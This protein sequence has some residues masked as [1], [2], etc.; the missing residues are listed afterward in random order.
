MAAVYSVVGYFLDRNNYKKGHVAYRKLD[1]LAA[2]NY[3]DSVINQWR[4]S[5]FGGYASLAYQEK[6]EC[7]DFQKALAQQE[8][9]NLPQALAAYKTFISKHNT[10]INNHDRDSVLV[11]A[12]RERIKSL[13]ESSEATALENPEVC[14][15]L[16]QLIQE[17]QE[18]LIPESNTK[19]SPLYVFCGENY[20]ANR[21]YNRAITMY[22]GFIAQYPHHA[23]V[24][25][26]EAALAKLLVAQAQEEGAGNLPALQREGNTGDSSS[27]VT[28][29]NNSPEPMRIVFSGPEGRIEKLEECGS[30]RIYFGKPPE[31]CPKQGPVGNYTLKPGEYDVVVKAIGNRPVNPFKGNWSLNSGGIYSNCFYIVTNPVERESEP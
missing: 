18:N 23:L 20:I 14:D 16:S 3:F 8:S 5:D 29:Q 30:C 25:Q 9:G 28:I 31:S 19:L 13:F 21:D 26:V 24:S 6:A 27:V 10:D 11:N 15:V 22:E 12:A 1:C 7:F 2:G 17:N 4:L